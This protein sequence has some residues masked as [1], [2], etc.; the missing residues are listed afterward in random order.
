MNEYS[1]LNVFQ[2]LYKW[3]KHI[4]LSTLAIGLLTAIVT[5]FMP[6]YYKATSTFYPASPSLANPNALGYDENAKYVYGGGEDLDRL[7]SI[8]ISE[9]V[10]NHLI[11]KF[12]LYKSY[13]IDSSSSKGKHMMMM[14]FKENYKC[15]RT[16][17]EAIELSVEDKDP[18]VAA[19]ITNEAREYTNLLIQ[20]LIKESQFKGI[21]SL[22]KNILLQE[23]K[24]SALAD[25]IQDVKSNSKMIDP[26]FQSETFSIEVIK[27]ES[28]LADAK[29]KADY[30]NKFESKKDSTIKY[31]A[32]AIGLESKV[33]QLRTRL[34]TFYEVGPW[35]KKKE[36]EYS[37]A[38]DQLSIEK[39]KLSQMLSSYNNAFTGLHIIDTAIPPYNKS[40]PKRMLIVLGAMFLTA[41]T[42]ILGI[43]M[44]NSFKKQEFK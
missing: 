29:A 17:Y 3:K 4:I 39:E 9:K 1:L 18:L 8:L 14:Q 19:N 31:R 32:I 12:D 38:A 2:E 27:A 20:K 24:V 33:A 10:M 16:K 41:I 43:L 44:L 11:S 40:R 25:S 13:D 21:E 36:V 30:Y 6:N 15:I 23:A 42:A 7:F 5:M 35:L 37:R 34:N 22:E 28:N 26:Y